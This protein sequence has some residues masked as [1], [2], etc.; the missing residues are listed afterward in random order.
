MNLLLWLRRFRHRC[1]YG[2]HSPWVFELVTGVIYEPSEYGFYA[3]S[4][5]PKV[6][7]WQSKN[8]KLLL[9]LAN[10]FQPECV[11]L[12]GVPEA[13]GLWMHAGCRTTR[14]QQQASDLPF[15]VMQ[16]GQR[17]CVIV[18]NTLTPLWQSLR[19]KGVNLDLY[20]LGLHYSGL[21][22]PD[23]SHIINYP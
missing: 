19:G 1:G 13:L 23:Q 21:P 9:R 22:I 18:F 2:I 14:L 8:L 16:S 11:T 3:Y 12:C 6:P 15:I 4:Q 17:Q 5:L 7:G 20:Y 10:H